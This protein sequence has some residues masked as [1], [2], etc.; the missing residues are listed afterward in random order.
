[1]NTREKIQQELRSFEGTELAEG[2]I[3]YVLV[4]VRSLGN[5]R[6]PRHPAPGDSI[7]IRE[8]G[9]TRGESWVALEQA[10]NAVRRQ[11]HGRKT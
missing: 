4:V 5:D 10:L 9:L 3:G 8:A 11:A 7:S 1:M 2:A 6:D